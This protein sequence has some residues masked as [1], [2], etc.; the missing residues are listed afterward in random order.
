MLLF[1]VP[2]Q[3]VEIWERLIT[4]IVITFVQ[5]AVKLFLVVPE[6]LPRKASTTCF[7]WMHTSR[8]LFYLL[9]VL[10]HIWLMVILLVR[11]QFC[12]MGELFLTNFTFER[13]NFWEK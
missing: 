12:R 6:F 3:A 5:F 8:G 1:L 9:L 11:G 13:I 4:L 7:T 2:V 10:I